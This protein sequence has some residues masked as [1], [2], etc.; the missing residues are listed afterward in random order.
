MFAVFKKESENNFSLVGLWNNDE[1]DKWVKNTI[2][3]LNLETESA[4]IVKFSKSDYQKIVNINSSN[5][6]AEITYDDVNDEIC[7]IETIRPKDLEKIEIAF[8]DADASLYYSAND[9]NQYQIVKNFYDNLPEEQ[10]PT[11]EEL[12]QYQ[13]PV[14]KYLYVE[15]QNKITNKLLAISG[16]EMNINQMIQNEE[17]N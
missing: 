5:F 12:E 10:E 17:D 16:I 15:S 3:K 1:S 11:P 7:C 6:N 13:Y 8:D 14:T 4:R 9:L 2:S